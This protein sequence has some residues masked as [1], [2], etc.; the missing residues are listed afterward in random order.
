MIDMNLQLFAEGG[1]DGG[2][3]GT[4]GAEGAEGTQGKPETNTGRKGAG[5]PLKAV[6]YGKQ[7]GQEDNTTESKPD[8]GAEARVKEGERRRAFES[9]I[10]GEYKDLYQKNVESLLQK[11]FKGHMQTAAEYEQAKPVINLLMEKY[12]AQDVQKLREAVENDTALFED[13]AIKRGLTPDQYK[14]LR[15][16]ETENRE[17]RETAEQKRRESEAMGI[18]NGWVEDAGKV[19]EKYP[20]FDFEAECGNPEFL[21]LL[22]SGV[23]ME[24]A[25][26]ALHR[27]EIIGGA[28]AYTAQTVRQQTLD[29]IRAGANRPIENGMQRNAGITVKT[30]ASRLTTADRK[31]IARRVERGERIE[32]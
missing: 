4:P 19:K 22:E 23:G 10:Y 7:E 13:E 28:L 18:Y 3:A 26:I 21:S 5:N 11:R 15:K 17:Y 16:L 20:D 2:A 32:F 29:T 31:E 14:Q 8:E 30:D 6:V 9:M 1:G 25:F 27:D 12:G 24:T